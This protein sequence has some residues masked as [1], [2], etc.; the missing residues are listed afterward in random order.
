M[1][2]CEVRNILKENDGSLPDVEFDFGTAPIA[3]TAY[4]LVQNRATAAESSFGH[5]WS[6]SR[7][8]DCPIVFGENP[9]LAFVD[10]DAEPFHVCFG[11]IKSS[12]GSAIPPLGFYVLDRGAVSLD[13]RMGPEW[14]SEAIAGLFE[15]MR[16][17]CGLSS[18]VSISH[19]GNEY[20]P[21]GETFLGA[22]QSWLGV[23]SNF[24]A[25]PGWRQPTQFRGSVWA[26]TIR[27]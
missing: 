14:N 9:A 15:L 26:L 23:N 1:S 24:H 5:Y 6:K 4:A 2:L 11:G 8:I 22:F 21:D 7:S 12:A 16:D 10:G 18:P 17:L 27:V 25:V 20:D 3:V 19:Q 13:I